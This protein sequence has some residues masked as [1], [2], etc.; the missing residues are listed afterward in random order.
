[1]ANLSFASK[2]EEE[3]IFQKYAI[4]WWKDFILLSIII[5]LWGYYL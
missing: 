4:V 2:D 3:T 1:M 5:S